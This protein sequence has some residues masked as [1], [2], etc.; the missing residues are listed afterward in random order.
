M[1]ACCFFVSKIDRKQVFLTVTLIDFYFSFT[2][3][4]ILLL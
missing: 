3:L 2:V 4:K 1:I